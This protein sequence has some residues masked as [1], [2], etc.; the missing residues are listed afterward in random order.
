[1]D[2]IRDFMVLLEVAKVHGVFR[3]ASKDS[4]K[5]ERTCKSD[6]YQTYTSLVQRHP[7]IFRHLSGQFFQHFSNNAIPFHPNLISFPVGYP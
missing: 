5:Y 6:D 1:M 2:L 3:E 7:R 4:P